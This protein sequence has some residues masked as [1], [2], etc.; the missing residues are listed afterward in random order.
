MVSGCYIALPGKWI[1]FIPSLFAH[2]Q[3][4]IFIIIVYFVTLIDI[5]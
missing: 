5:T 1:I 2:M 3:M 4:L